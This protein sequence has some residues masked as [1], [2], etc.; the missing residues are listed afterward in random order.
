MIASSPCRQIYESYRRVSGTFCK[1][2][3]GIDRA[4]I[5]HFLSVPPNS[6][7]YERG[8]PNA[9]STAD[10]SKHRIAVNWQRIRS[11]APGPRMPPT[12][13]KSPLRT[14]AESALT[15]Q[16]NHSLGPEASTAS[17]TS[18]I[19]SR[20]ARP[21]AR[22]SRR[23][24]RGETLHA[25]QYPGVESLHGSRSS[26]IIPPIS[27]RRCSP[28]RGRWMAAAAAR[29]SNVCVPAVERSTLHSPPSGS[30]PPAPP[31]A[32]RVHSA[33]HRSAPLRQL[34][35]RTPASGNHFHARTGDRLGGRCRGAW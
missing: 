15:R 23:I 18:P 22:W 31:A 17:H 34:C 14:C 6:E 7:R 21:A 10:A 24:P 13:Y 28:P 16:K 35:P 29:I 9:K 26:E 11:L 1:A 27:P 5:D 3:L 19:P 25:S 20:G 33:P 30:P 4:P 12:T 8:L 32:S 2:R